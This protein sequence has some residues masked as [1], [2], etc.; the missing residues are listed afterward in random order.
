M[1]SKGM[2]MNMLEHHAFH[3]LL[4]VVVLAAIGAWWFYQK[5]SDK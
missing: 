5:R 2:H 1:N 3:I 4:T